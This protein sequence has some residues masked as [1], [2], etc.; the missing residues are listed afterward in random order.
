MGTSPNKPRGYFEKFLAIDCE[1]TGLCFGTDNPVHN[2][3]T[4][5]RHQSVSWGAIVVNAHTLTPIEELYVEI[6]WNESSL[7]QRMNNRNFGK[8]AEKIHGLSLEYLEENGVEEE[9]AVIQLGNLVLKHFGDSGI[10]LLGHNVITFDR[11]FFKD[12]FSRHD[13]ELKF[14]NRYIDTNTLGFVCYETFNSDELFDIVGVVRKEHNALEDAKAS[15]K[16]AQVTRKLF[17]TMLED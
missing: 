9:E 2:P 5:E 11:L 4:G 3:Q 17:K 8:D 12:L 16:V 13:I 10:R 7:V 15:L 1:T 14:G 6:K